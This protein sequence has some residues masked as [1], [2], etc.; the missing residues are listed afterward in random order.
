MCM[1]RFSGNWA[2]GTCI[3]KQIHKTFVIFEF[4]FILLHYVVPMFQ[5][6]LDTVFVY[7]LTLAH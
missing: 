4:S 2:K 1:F 3:W 5:I 7:K 6:Y